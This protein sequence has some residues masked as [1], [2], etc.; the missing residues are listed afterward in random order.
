MNQIPCSL[1]HTYSPPLRTRPYTILWCKLGLLTSLLKT[2]SH[3]R[4]DGLLATA[5]LA[6]F[7]D[8]HRCMGFY[9]NKNL[10]GKDFTMVA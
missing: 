3:Y 10:Y 6:D 9:M 2:C 8:F 4:R 7:S 5:T 1:W